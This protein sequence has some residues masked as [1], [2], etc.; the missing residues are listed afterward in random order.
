MSSPTTYALRLAE[1]EKEGEGWKYPSVPYIN[2]TDDFETEGGRDKE[3]VVHTNFCAY[4]ALHYR[5]LFAGKHLIAEG[6]LP[7]PNYTDMGGQVWYCC[8]PDEDVSIF[9]CAN[10]RT[11]GIIKFTTGG[12]PWT[13]LMENVEVSLLNRAVS[14][15]HGHLTVEMRID[16]GMYARVS[17]IA[18]KAP[19]ALRRDFY[20]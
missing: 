17:H 1:S 11:D 7:Q 16:L 2:A 19:G 15:S 9:M 3:S 4:S 20:E 14:V 10:T 12:P 5:I 6:F 18:K 13:P 8:P